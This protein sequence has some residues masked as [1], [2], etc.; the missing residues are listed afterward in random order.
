MI[1][2]KTQ[3]NWDVSTGLLQT[4]AFYIQSFQPSPNNALI[5][6]PCESDRVAA[7]WVK[8]KTIWRSCWGS[9]RASQLCHAANAI[10]RSI[11]QIQAYVIGSAHEIGIL[12]AAKLC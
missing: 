12:M 11:R 2:I 5:F 7:Y 4:S 1:P 8:C 10:A 6:G 9:G 3:N